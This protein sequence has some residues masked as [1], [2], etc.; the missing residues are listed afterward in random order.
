MTVGTTDT[1]DTPGTVPVDTG[2]A[3]AVTGT[4]VTDAAVS[5]TVE[6]GTV[7][8]GTVLSA[9]ASLGAVVAGT[10]VGSS[11]GAGF[12]QTDRDVDAPM[13]GKIVSRMA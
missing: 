2:P 5:G 13:R 6:A 8:A 7:V 12:C 4:V 10:V 3:G 11:A 9:A 1:A